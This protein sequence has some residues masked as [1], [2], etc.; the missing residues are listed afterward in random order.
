MVSPTQDVGTGLKRTPAIKRTNTFSTKTSRREPELRR[1][2]TVSR[3]AGLLVAKSL[4]RACELTRQPAVRRPNLSISG[5]ELETGL[6]ENQDGDNLSARKVCSSRPFSFT[7]GTEMLDLKQTQ[8]IPMATILEDMQRSRQVRFDNEEISEPGKFR[9]HASMLIN[10]TSLPQPKTSH[11]PLARNAD[12]STEVI[13]LNN[14]LRAVSKQLDSIERIYHR[15]NVSAAMVLKIKAQVSRFEKVLKR[16]HALGIANFD[17]AGSAK[18]SQD[19]SNRIEQWR[20][21]IQVMLNIISSILR[22][23]AGQIKNGSLIAALT[24]S[25]EDAEQFVASFDLDG[26]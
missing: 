21:I 20:S 3:E 19:I 24:K 8:V 22:D 9:T 10:G 26:R 15:G 12:P 23:P 5:A 25:V 1:S 16:L 6:E 13:L 11:L 14:R 18:V 7:R 2:N 4:D 17:A